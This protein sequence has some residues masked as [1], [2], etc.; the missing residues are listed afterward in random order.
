MVGYGAVDDYEAGNEHPGNELLI[1]RK[2]GNGHLSEKN[3]K[4]DFIVEG[5]GR[6]GTQYYC[7]FS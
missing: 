1:T 4:G 5:A 6:N 7:Q 2:K 3:H